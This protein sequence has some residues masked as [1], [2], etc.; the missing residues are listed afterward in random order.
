MLDFVAP[1]R[2]T[3]GATVMQRERLEGGHRT[4]FERVSGRDCNADSEFTTVMSTWSVA[5][6]VF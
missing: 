6:D 2:E 5:V 4:L 1:L 3:I